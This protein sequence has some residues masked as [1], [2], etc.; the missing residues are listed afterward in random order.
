M[1]FGRSRT[2]HR[3]ALFGGSFDPPHLGHVAICKWLFQRGAA[4]E[5]WVIPCFRHPFD[6]ALSPFEDR[7]AM[8]QLAFR[9]QGLPI[10]VLDIERRLG[11]VS[12]TL[13]TI[14]ALLQEY[15]DWR[16]TFVTGADVESDSAGWHRFDAIRELVE[17]VRLPRGPLSPIPDISSTEIRRRVHDDE[18]FAD[19]VEEEI[20]VYILTKHLYR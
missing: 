14:E 19:L 18:P 17:I 2:R 10:E 12:Y 6:K 13:R 1:V 11:G 20:A 15:P 5:V 4:D 8:C 7:Y 16:F 9:K 3:V